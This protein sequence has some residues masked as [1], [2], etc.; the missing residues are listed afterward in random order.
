MLDMATGG[1]ITS[2]NMNPLDMDTHQAAVLYE[3]AMEYRHDFPSTAANVI[4][5]LLEPEEDRLSVAAALNML[6]R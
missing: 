4:C 1:S 2:A 3:L 5:G 6:E